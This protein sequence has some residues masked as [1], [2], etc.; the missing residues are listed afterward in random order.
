MRTCKSCHEDK[1]ETEFYLVKYGDKRYFR[2]RCK[3][4]MSTYRH[5]NYII[6][7]WEKKAKKIRINACGRRVAKKECTVGQVYLRELYCQQKGL[8][9]LTGIEMDMSMNTGSRNPLCLS[10]DRIDD[11]KGYIPG[12]VRLVIHW[13]NLSR[14]KGMSD[15]DLLKMCEAVSVCMKKTGKHLSL[16]S[17]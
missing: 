1:E 2:G 16:V 7:Y 15:A 9:A 10:V 14:M 5:D 13:V 8:C 11:S 12:N 17:K 6:G 4:C 3:R